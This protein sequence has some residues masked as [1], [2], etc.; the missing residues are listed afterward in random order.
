MSADILG[1]SCDQCRSMVQCI[2]T[3]TEARGLV[4]TMTAT[5]TLTQLLN[6]ELWRRWSSVKYSLV[7]RLT[8]VRWTVHG[9][10]LNPARSAQ[11]YCWHYMFQVWLENGLKALNGSWLKEVLL[12]AYCTDVYIY[13]YIYI[14]LL[15]YPNQFLFMKGWH[16][17][18]RYFFTIIFFVVHIV[19]MRV[20]AWQECNCARNKRWN[21]SDLQLCQIWKVFEYF[22]IILMFQIFLLKIA[23]RSF[24]R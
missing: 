18:G 4:R 7:P 21:W 6:Y 17:C 15:T 19:C 13:I 11:Y 2:F 10:G 12:N 24:Q 22:Y 20:R 14:C 16:S 5:S 23:T 3:S 8:S 9:S 1:T